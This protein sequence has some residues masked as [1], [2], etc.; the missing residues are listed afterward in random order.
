MVMVS[1]LL[2]LTVLDCQAVCS[3]D[4]MT[5]LGRN[6]YSRRRKDVTLRLGPAAAATWQAHLFAKVR[7]FSRRAVVFKL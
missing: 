7:A 2:V 6:W 4:A 5:Q 3:M 1:R